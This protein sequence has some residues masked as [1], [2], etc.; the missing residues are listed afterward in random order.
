L[1]L[2]RQGEE[3]AAEYLIKLG[4]QILQRNYR[5]PR[6]EIDLLA[7]QGD[8]LVIVEVKSRRS[9]LYGE[10]FESVTKAKQKKLRLLAG[11]YL[12]DCQTFY[13]TIRFDVISLLF[14]HQGG[15]VHLKHFKEAF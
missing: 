10:G 9:L 14:D 6:G 12:S 7:N 4:Y 13:A 15:L 1:R 5:T 8:T 3:L 2:G 11:I